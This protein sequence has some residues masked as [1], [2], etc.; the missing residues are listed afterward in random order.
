MEE[1]L[2]LPIVSY[3]I[4]L[5]LTIKIYF[6]LS[7]SFLTLGAI[8]THS[9]FLSIDHWFRMN[10]TKRMMIQSSLYTLNSRF[11]IDIQIFNKFFISSLY[12]TIYFS[13]YFLYYLAQGDCLSP[14][15]ISHHQKMLS[16]LPNIRTSMRQFLS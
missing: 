16:V 10:K 11:T 4:L 2:R 13:F 12:C 8:H 1:S 9:W 6:F 3:F 14:K 15:S 5:Y 7:G